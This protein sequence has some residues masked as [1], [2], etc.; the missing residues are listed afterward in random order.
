VKLADLVVETVAAAALRAEPVDDA[1]ETA[2]LDVA[3]DEAEAEAD[4]AC[5]LELLIAEEEA[6]AED[7]EAMAEEEAELPAA[8]VPFVG[9]E[10]MLIPSTMGE[11]SS[12]A[13][14]RDDQSSTRY[15]CQPHIISKDCEEEMSYT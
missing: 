3:P 12:W 7:E 1:D 5:E 2:D 4:E 6:E 9:G 10:V 11:V 13:F 15:S 8:R 14:Y